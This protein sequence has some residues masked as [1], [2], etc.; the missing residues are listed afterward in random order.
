MPLYI[1]SVRNNDQ[2]KVVFVDG[3]HLDDLKYY[4]NSVNL[5]KVNYGL[6]RL[7]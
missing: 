2:S 3:Y 4:E 1:V 5:H 7:L 6:F